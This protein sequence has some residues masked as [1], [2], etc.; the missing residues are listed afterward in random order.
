[1]IFCCPV[2][3]RRLEV[4]LGNRE[5]YISQRF[6]FILLGYPAQED[7]AELLSQALRLSL[8]DQGKPPSGSAASS[9]AAAARPASRLVPR[10]EYMPAS[11]AAMT[12]ECALACLPKGRCSNTGRLRS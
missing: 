5:Y 6:C 10:S 7:E 4:P 12:D 3:I 8:A 9:S 1:M 2:D 11:V